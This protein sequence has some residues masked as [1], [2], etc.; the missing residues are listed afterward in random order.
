MKVYNPLLYVVVYFNFTLKKPKKNITT[1]IKQ[2]QLTSNK[3]IK[4]N[5]TKTKMYFELLIKKYEDVTLE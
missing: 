1:L 2:K 3:I 5:L 4:K